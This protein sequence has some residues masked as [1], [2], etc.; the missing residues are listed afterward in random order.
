MKVKEEVVERMNLSYTHGGENDRFLIAF[1][2]KIVISFFIWISP[3]L[4]LVMFTDILGCCVSSR[5][6]GFGGRPAEMRAI[7]QSNNG[8]MMESDMGLF[9][10]STALAI[11]VPENS[12]AVRGYFWSLA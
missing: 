3:L 4:A 5:C 1:A 8:L 7:E 9:T 12:T 2:V 6:L 11:F 10:V